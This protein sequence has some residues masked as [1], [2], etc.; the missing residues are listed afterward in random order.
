[1]PSQISPPNG[2]TG[3]IADQ[4]VAVG[5]GADISGSGDLTWDDNDKILRISD[6][7]TNG[8]IGVDTSS[9]TFYISANNRLGIGGLPFASSGDLV[10][11]K[12]FSIRALNHAG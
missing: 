12:V 3:S 10:F 1:M 5:N 8:Q 11:P 6:G 9:G 7:A 2:L 4:Q